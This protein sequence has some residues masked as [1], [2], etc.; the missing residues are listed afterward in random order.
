MPLSSTKEFEQQ[1]INVSIQCQLKAFLLL[2]CKP[3]S[4]QVI[5]ARLQKLRQSPASVPYLECIGSVHPESDSHSTLQSDIWRNNLEDN[6]P[7][8]HRPSHGF[9]M[10][11][12]L[13]KCLAC[14][15]V[16]RNVDPTAGRVMGGRHS[17][18]I[19]VGG[20]RTLSD[21]HVTQSFSDA[22]ISERIN[23][24]GG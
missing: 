8:L 22:S 20:I 15:N 12:A 16:I 17:P 19:F 7:C 2:V 11:R 21:D 4:N 1:Y 14:P 10:L 9:H 18:W 23:V 13:D 5:H 6:T 3:P 24:S